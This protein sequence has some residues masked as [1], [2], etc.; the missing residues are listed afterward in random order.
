MSYEIELGKKKALNEIAEGVEKNFIILDGILE[1]LKRANDLKEIE[2]G[3]KCKEDYPE[4][5]IKKK[6]RRI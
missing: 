3:I 6:T 5:E 1:E 2:L 4:R